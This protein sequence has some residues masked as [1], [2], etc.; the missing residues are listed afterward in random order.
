MVWVKEQE[1]VFKEIKRA[2]TISPAQDLPD[3]IETFPPI[4]T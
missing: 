1:K 3:V 2:L 4:C